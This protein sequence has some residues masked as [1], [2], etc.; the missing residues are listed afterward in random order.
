MAR[1]KRSDQHDYAWIVVV[2]MVVC[3]ILTTGIF[4]RLLEEYPA[5]AAFVLVSLVG[6]AWF[7]GS[8]EGAEME[9]YAKKVLDDTEKMRADALM[10]QERADQ[11]SRRTQEETQSLHRQ[12]RALE[13]MEQ[14]CDEKNRGTDTSFIKMSCEL[15]LEKRI[16]VSLRVGA[17]PS[18]PEE[19]YQRRRRELVDR[20][21]REWR[22]RQSF[23]HSLLA[24]VEE[25]SGLC[26]N[27]KKDPSRGGCGAYLYN[28]PPTAVHA[29]HIRPQSLGGSDDYDNLQALCS[30]C[31]ISKGNRT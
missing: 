1:R 5:I 17:Y 11:L 2:A 3:V 21:V 9:S 26:G 7:A 18:E 8:R 14:A 22:A 28:F 27:P 29:D 6:A 20:R 12:R 10:H 4:Q 16:E 23:G 30:F 24:L 31:N 13:A 15:P 25:Q 19:I